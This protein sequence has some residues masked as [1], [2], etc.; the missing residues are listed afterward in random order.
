[1]VG[2]ALH[3]LPHHI[4][5][6][7]DVSSPL[8]ERYLVLLVLHRQLLR[9]LDPVPHRAEGLEDR[10]VQDLAHEVLGRWLDSSI[11]GP[12]HVLELRDDRER[13]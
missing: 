2:D 8:H 5:R 1:L 13:S 4:D 9:C 12:D 3:E 6:H 11:W 7:A 10:V